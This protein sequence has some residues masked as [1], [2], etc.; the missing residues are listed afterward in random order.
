MLYIIQ[1]LKTIAILQEHII[2]WFRSKCQDA[3][4]Q[5]FNLGQIQQKKQISQPYDIYCC[6]AGGEG[7]QF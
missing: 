5:W 3:N 2:F 7:S 1:Y 6:F 4:C